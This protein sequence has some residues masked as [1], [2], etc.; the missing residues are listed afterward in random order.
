MA[1]PGRQIVILVVDDEVI[2]RNIV[3]RIL[4]REGFAVL[5]A[6]DGQEALELL[7]TFPDT[8]E[9]LLT[10]IE[11][12]RLDG[13][14]LARQVRGKNGKIKIMFMSGKLAD[15]QAEPINF[16]SKPFQPRALLIRVHETLSDLLSV[17]STPPDASSDAE[18]LS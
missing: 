6:A 18:L 15:N 13:L 1:S 4:I 7:E 12:P 2:V 3:Q 17:K 14:N 16:I 11:M 9:L 5:S 8:I 10:D